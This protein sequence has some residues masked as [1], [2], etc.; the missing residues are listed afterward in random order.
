M[1]TGNTAWILVAS[2]MVLLM[3]PGLA[4]FYGGLVRE[5]QVVNTIKMSVIAMGVISDAGYGQYFVH[6]VG[7]WIG[8]DVHDVGGRAPIQ[9]NTLFTIEPG[10]YIPEE[11]L[12]IRIED[13]YLMTADGAVKLSAAIPSDPEELEALIRSL[14]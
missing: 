10:I 2:A 13:D 8:L 9:L 11:N 1:D 5:R 12:G 6:G 4:F 14:R 3:T 7:H